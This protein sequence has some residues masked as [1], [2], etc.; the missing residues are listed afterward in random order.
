MLRLCEPE[1]PQYTRHLSAQRFAPVSWL[2]PTTSVSGKTIY[3]VLYES[4]D[5]P[6]AMRAEEHTA[7]IDSDAAR[8]R[9][10]EFEKGRIHLL[11]S[12]TTFEIGVDLGD[13]E[14]VFL[15]NVPPEPFNY[16]QRVGRAGRREK[17]GLALT[18]CRRN[19]HDLHHFENPEE[20]IIRGSVRPPRLRMTNQKIIYRHMAAAALSAFFK[21]GANGER[22]A[23]VKSLIGD[24]A[25]PRAVFRS[26]AVSARTTKR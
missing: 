22:F 13:L 4:C 1:C 23:N 26:Q 20:R 8:E 3:R 15:R 25:C 16:T 19:P 9:Q 24:W 5:L 21:N 14:A 11:S 10:D 18:Y 7:Q 12:S 2:S 6:P 17:P